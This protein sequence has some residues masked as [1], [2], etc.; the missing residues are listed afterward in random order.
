MTGL[1]PAG[2]WPTPSPHA[3]VCVNDARAFGSA[4]G[5]APRSLGLRAVRFW[6]YAW[7]GTA[8]DTVPCR[9]ARTLV[10]SGVLP[11]PPAGWRLASLG[12]RLAPLGAEPRITTVE[13][14]ALMVCFQ[15]PTALRPV[16]DW[17]VAEVA[18]D[19]AAGGWT[20]LNT[21]IVGGA[22]CGLSERRPMP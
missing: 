11:A 17:T 7:P 9:I 10:S 13:T 19:G 8:N 3:R 6:L 15:R 20:R 1:T 12:V 2:P 22:L 14:R 5:G 4:W 16:D 18:G 21:R